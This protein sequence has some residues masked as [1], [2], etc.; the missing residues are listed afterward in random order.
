LALD[1][2]VLALL[3]LAALYGAATGALRQLVSLA[4]AA[5]GVLAARAFTAP[6]ADGLARTISPFVRPA[7]PVLLF[8]GVFALG[9]LIGHLVLRATRVARAVR[10]PADR[11]AGA[12]LGGAKG[13]LAAWIL[14]SALVLAG[15]RA[16]EALLRRIRGS[17]FA[18]LARTHN[19]V[20]SLD[21][22]AARTLERALRAARQAER[23]GRLA[24]DPES[25]RLRRDPR[26]RALEEGGP[27]AP[28]DP[29][30]SARALED[31]ELRALVERLAGRGGPGP[32]AAPPAPRP[33]PRRL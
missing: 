30:R 14:L 23:A 9:S 18:A 26:I 1:L 29:D 7:A 8:A 3:A 22:G 17:D 11:G 19:L 16:P 24:R 21:P 13:L 15:D 12:L 31:P 33:P 27:D 32:E 28:L 25:A 2:A 6:V 5:L 10:G 20:R 4:A